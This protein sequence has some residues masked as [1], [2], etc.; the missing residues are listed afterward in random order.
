MRTETL[1]YLKENA[2]NLELDS[3]LLVTQNGKARY[4]IQNAEDYEFQQESLALLKLLTIS[5]QC[6]LEGTISLE[7]AFSHS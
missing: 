1:T 6:S 4:V 2:N 5:S 3:P 7:D